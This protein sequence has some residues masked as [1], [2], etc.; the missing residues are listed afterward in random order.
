[1]YIP[2][3]LGTSRDGSVSSSVADFAFQY[4][5]ELNKFDTELL[6]TK[7]FVSIP[8]T[9]GAMN[10]EMHDKWQN[11][12]SRADGFI[13]V[14]PEY[15]HSFPGE[16][17]LMIDETL[18]EYEKKPFAICGVSVR[19]TGG[20]KMM[21][22]LKGVISE[23]RGVAVRNAVYFSHAHKI[24]D[25][26]QYKESMKTQINNMLAELIWYAQALET[27]RSVKQ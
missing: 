27:G 7:D 16:L 2:I 17:K 24:L 13:I 12:A 1:M 11:S 19:A 4:I 3:I 23:I 20:A 9:G 26:P 5:K 21:E 22:S 14:S 6:K 8:S 25:E 18:K 15:N 10:K